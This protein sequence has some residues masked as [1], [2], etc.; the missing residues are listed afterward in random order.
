MREKEELGEGG[1]GGGGEKGGEKGA[2]RMGDGDNLD[3]LQI[4][5]CYVLCV[6]LAEQTP[7]TLHNTA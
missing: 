7:V 4:C 5:C 3:G 6:T 1:G 2:K